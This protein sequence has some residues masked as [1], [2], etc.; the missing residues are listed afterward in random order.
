MLWKRRGYVVPPAHGPTILYSLL[1]SR[2]MATELKSFTSV[3]PFS[4][5]SSSSVYMAS[6]L[7]TRISDY[8]RG[9]ICL[10]IEGFARYIYIYLVP[11]ARLFIWP[12]SFTEKELRLKFLMQ[13]LRP[14]DSFL[15]NAWQYC[16]LAHCTYKHCVF[17]PNHREE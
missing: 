13:L 12:F 11:K 6:L 7:E 10:L 2:G 1:F 14:L 3:I 5:S 8:T 4:A 9:Y 17:A 15:P 16:V